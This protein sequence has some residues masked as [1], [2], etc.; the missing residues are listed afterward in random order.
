M[1]TRD[2]DAPGAEARPFLRG[3]RDVMPLLIATM[4]F[5]IVYGALS[6]KEGLTLVETT[7]MSALVFAGA[8]QFV[9]LELWADPLP[10]WTILL[11]VLAVNL[12]HVLYSAAFG[13]KIGGWPPAERYSAFFFLTDPTFAL[14]ELDPAGRLKPAY[15]F[16]ISLPLYLNWIVATLIGALFGDLIRRPEAIGFDFVATAYFIFLV[17]GFRGRPNAVP[18]I[19]ASAAGSLLAYFAVGS[20]WHYAGGAIAGIAIAALMAGSRRAV[21]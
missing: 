4:P 11:S 10:F 8:S 2:P 6:A 21:P 13:R 14:A 16:G 12:R 17:V 15:Y 1:I 9:A 3:V 18:V 20:P 5:G 7:A 19:L